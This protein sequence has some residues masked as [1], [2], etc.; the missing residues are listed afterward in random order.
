MSHLPLVVLTA[1]VWHFLGLT[2]WAHEQVILEKPVRVVTSSSLEIFPEAWRNPTVAPGG[3]ALPQ[4]QIERAR[5]IVARALAKYPPSVLASNLKAV[6]AL[7]EL[8]Y[9][10]VVTSGTNSRTSVYLK[11]GPEKKGF[12]ATHIEGVFHAE[13]SSILIRNHARL[14]DSSSWHGANPEGFRYLGDG[15]DAVKQGKAGL[16]SQ[17]SLLE[18]GFLSEYACSTL[19]NDLN[20]IAMR[21][22]TG[23][24]SLW[25][26]AAQH[27]RIQK[28]LD[29]TLAFYQ[30]L[31]PAFTEAFFMA[32]RP[33]TDQAVSNLSNAAHNAG[34][35]AQGF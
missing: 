19:E 35:R 3:S 18:K 15:V 28:K 8:R 6:Y 4:E 22:F 12:T 16:K 1:T 34:V 2:C 5:L 7:E 33:M 10:G 23:D 13:F 29:L 11:F 14:L 26:V 17:E 30:K 21:L 31:D 25:T 24:A 32:M 20:G 27:P 9:R